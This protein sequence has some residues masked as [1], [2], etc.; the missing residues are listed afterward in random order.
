MSA[1]IHR[2][3]L[4][5]LPSDVLRIL[6][7]S[8]GLSKVE[9]RIAL[10][11]SC[12]TV[13]HA[14]GAVDTMT[15]QISSDGGEAHW[16]TEAE[17]AGFVRQAGRR[18]SEGLRWRTFYFSRKALRCASCCDPITHPYNWLSGAWCD[19]F[20][21]CVLRPA[22]PRRAGRRAAECNVHQQC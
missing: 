5:D 1:E 4:A 19:P 21:L 12:K 15:G 14:C 18:P 16:R 2:M 7:Y 6:V 20:Q 17:I 13:M 9:D 11:L 8:S 10:L 22:H 3:S